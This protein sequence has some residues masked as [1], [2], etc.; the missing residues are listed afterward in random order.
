[1][2]RRSNDERNIIET[3]MMEMQKAQDATLDDYPPGAYEYD[4]DWD[5]DYRRQADYDFAHKREFGRCNQVIPK[6]DF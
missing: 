6:R 4:A 5:S 1:M 2:G 3:E